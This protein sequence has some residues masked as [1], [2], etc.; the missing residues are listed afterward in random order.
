MKPT[1]SPLTPEVAAESPEIAGEDELE[2]L[3]YENEKLQKI[4]RVLMRRVE[5]GWGNHSDAYQSFEET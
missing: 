4:N 3:R 1:S 2:R 5:M